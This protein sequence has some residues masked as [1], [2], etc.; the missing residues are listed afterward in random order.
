MQHGRYAVE[1][2]L[3]G[4]KGGCQLTHRVVVHTEEYGELFEVFEVRIG[5]GQI[6]LGQ[7]TQTTL[8]WGTE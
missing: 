6:D 3:S 7:S 4:A 2:T 5:A 8:R 1:E